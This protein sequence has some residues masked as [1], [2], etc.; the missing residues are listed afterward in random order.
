MD[1]GKLR[2]LKKL[3]DE[4]VQLYSKLKSLFQEKRKILISNKVDDL[5]IVDE[6]ILNIVDSIK[7][8]VNLRERISE[9]PENKQLTLSQIIAEAEKYDKDLAHEFSLAQQEVH[10][11]I[12]EI[13]HEEMV[14]K[15]LLRHGMNLVNKT[16]NMISNAAAI[17]GEYN[18][19]GKNT[20]SEID[21]ISSV[22]E[23]V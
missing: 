6:K 19:A 16:L 11:L 3:I 17:A 5:L 8:S 20:H 18:S 7:S 10:T 13:S 2:G 15:E 21:R 12:K 4:E 23:E 9:Q 1:L 22:I 14:I